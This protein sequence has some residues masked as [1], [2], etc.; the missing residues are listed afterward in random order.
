MVLA[1]QDYPD[2]PRRGDVT[3]SLDKANKIGEVFRVGTVTNEKGEVVTNGDRVLCIA[4]LSG[5]V[6]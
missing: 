2:S 1:T 5:D 3:P 4:G 6:A